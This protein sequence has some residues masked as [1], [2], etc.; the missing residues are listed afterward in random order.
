MSKLIN[1][2]I[3]AVVTSVLSAG[4]G[5]GPAKNAGNI[6]IDCI[7]ADHAKIDAVIIDLGT[8]KRADGTRDWGAIEADAIANG[9]Q[10][11]GCAL[12]QFIQSYLTPGAGVKAPADGLQARETLEHYRTTQANGATFKTAQGAL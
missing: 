10:I 5:C 12:A 7:A 8:K 3:A 4:S 6:V 1:L 2:C 9:L 11:G